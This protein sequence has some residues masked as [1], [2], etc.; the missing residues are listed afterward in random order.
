MARPV[1]KT[2]Q[3]RVDEVRLYL[4]QSIAGMVA[5]ATQIPIH[6]A[7]LAFHV[8]IGTNILALEAILKH[9]PQ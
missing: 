9:L 6:P 1:D 7:N 3:L 5:A 2:E 8:Q 4:E